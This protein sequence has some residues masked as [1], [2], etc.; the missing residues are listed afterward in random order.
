MRRALAAAVAVTAA[1][2]ALAAPVSPAAAA[3]A[4]RVVLDDPADA[5][6]HIDL[7]RATFRV[8][9]KMAGFSAVVDD[10]PV[11]GAV[12]VTAS[13]PGSDDTLD[14]VLER[15]PQRKVFAYA[16]YNFLEDA[17]GPIRCRTTHQWNRATDVVAI[18]V[19][20]GCVEK[21]V[22]NLDRD[23]RFDRVE[24]RVAAGTRNLFRED[25]AGPVQL[26][27]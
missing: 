10:L 13:T 19:S 1:V 18:S 3:S 22:R 16:E 7:R 25:V 17:G 9:E 4:T 20:R 26:F 24:M 8:G 6:A 5:R 23:L 12:H 21:L 11:A 2:T 14:L 27:S 15:T